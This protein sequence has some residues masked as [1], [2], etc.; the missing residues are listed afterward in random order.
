MSL[1]EQERARTAQ[2]LSAHADALGL[3]HEQIAQKAGLGA[4]AVDGILSMASG[5]PVATWAVRDVLDAEARRRGVDAG[6]WSVLT[7]AAR[8]Q[9]TRWFALRDVA[10]N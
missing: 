4:D 9:A 2:E 5:D 3:T 1:N 10:S 6:G 8:V 7:D